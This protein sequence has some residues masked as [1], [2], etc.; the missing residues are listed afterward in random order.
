[1]ITLNEVMNGKEIAN[2]KIIDGMLVVFEAICLDKDKKYFMKKI[3]GTGFQIHEDKTY[4]Y[5]GK[6]DYWFAVNS[7]TVKIRFNKIL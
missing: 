5:V 6:E 2:L 1:M 3:K 7:K 4:I